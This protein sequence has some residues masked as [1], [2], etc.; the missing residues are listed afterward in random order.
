MYFSIWDLVIIIDKLWQLIFVFMC[1]L[2]FILFSIMPLVRM[3]HVG[4]QLT[5]ST[6]HSWWLELRLHD[7]SPDKHFA[8]IPSL[9]LAPSSGCLAI[10]VILFDLLFHCAGIV[11]YAL[12][13]YAIVSLHYCSFH[14]TLACI[15]SLPL[16]CYVQ[17]YLWN[18]LL[19]WC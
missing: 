3:C 12:I 4:A 10:L 16:M 13:V 6:L 19:I 18:L 11:L 17:Y 14:L 7:A 15:Y 5:L 2:I 1:A 8:L 9:G